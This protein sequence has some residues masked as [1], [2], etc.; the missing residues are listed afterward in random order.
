[1]LLEESAAFGAASENDKESV[2]LLRFVTPYKTL[3]RAKG[4]RCGKRMEDILWELRRVKGMLMGFN[5]I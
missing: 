2:E 1:M 5:R 4:R 3:G